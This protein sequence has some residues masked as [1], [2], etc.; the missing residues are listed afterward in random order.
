MKTGRFKG[1][2]GHSEEQKGG[3]EQLWLG[4]WD[5]AGERSRWEVLDT[6]VAGVRGRGAKESL[7]TRENSLR[8]L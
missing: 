8:R 6:C 2:K 3:T 5:Q 4:G 7:E 1:Q